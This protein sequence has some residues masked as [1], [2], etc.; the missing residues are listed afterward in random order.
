M[1]RNELSSSGIDL[2][3]NRRAKEAGEDTAVDLQK[4]HHSDRG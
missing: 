2:M 1:N 4:I 3:N